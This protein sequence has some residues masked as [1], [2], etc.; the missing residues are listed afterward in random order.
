MQQ[1]FFTLDINKANQRFKIIRFCALFFKR[2]LL[3]KIYYYTFFHFKNYK[4]I[5]TELNW[6][7][8]R[9][10]LTQSTWYQTDVPPKSMWKSVKLSFTPIK[11]YFC[12]SGRATS[13][14]SG[15]SSGHNVDT[16]LT[17]RTTL[18]GSTISDNLKQNVYHK[19]TNIRLFKISIPL[20]PDT[21]SN[22]YTIHKTQWTFSF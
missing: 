22:K 13:A 7:A 16:Q 14:S 4:Q 2:K 1:T 6:Y 18:G 3:L 10:L 21:H 8:I 19:D 5:R 17:C 20:L 11:Q 9:G 15:R 12:T